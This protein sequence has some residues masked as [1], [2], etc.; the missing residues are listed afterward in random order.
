MLFLLLAGVVW[1]LARGTETLF[2]RDVFNAHLPMKQAQAEALR[3]GRMPLIDPYRAGGQPLAGN[4]NAVP[5]YPDNVLYLKA[6]VV[7]ALNAHFWI[8][9]LVAPFAFAWLARAWGIGR[10]GAWVAAALWTTGGFFL[11]HLSFYNLIAGV[12][13][14]PAFVAAVLDLVLRPERR[15]SLPLMAGLWGLLLLS[16]DPL[17]AGLALLVGVGAAV[18]ALAWRRGSGEG[19]DPAVAGRGTEVGSSDGGDRSVVWVGRKRGGDGGLRFPGGGMR[20]F[21]S[22]ALGM[23]GAL[24]AGTLLA[25][26][27]LVEFWRILALSFRGHWGFTAQAATIASWDP[28]QVVEQLIPFAFGRPD[29]LE[30]GSFW[31]SRF[32]TGFPPYYFSLYPGLLAFALA[33]AA[34]FRGGLRGTRASVWAWGAIAF[35]VFFSLGRFNPLASWL[36]SL[37]GG[38]ALRYPVKFWLPVAMG[39]ALLGGLG[40]EALRTDLRARRRFGFA[41]ALLAGLFGLAWTL[42]ALR[43]D[44]SGAWLRGWVPASFSEGFVVSERLRLAALCAVSLVLL[45]GLAVAFRVLRRWPVVGAALLVALH[46][47]S[48]LWLMRPLRPTDAVVPYRVPPPALDFVP[49]EAEVV[50]GAYLRLFGSSD[51]GSGRFPAPHSR[52]LER[53]AFFELYPM[54]GAQWR[55]RY[56]LNVSPEG[57]DSFLTRVSQGAVKGAPDAARV[58]LLAAW[59]VD[60]LL[61]DRPLDGMAGA[62]LA[63]IP[64]SGGLLHVYEVGGSAPDVYVARRI[65]RAPHLQAAVGWMLDPR[66]DP[67]ADVVLPGEGPIEEGGGGRVLRSVAADPEDLEVEVAVGGPSYL[68]VQ[69]AHLP[70]YRAS[71]DGETAAVEVGNLHRI[72]VAVPAG[73]HRVRLWVE[74][75]SLPWSFAASGVGAL[76]VALLAF[77]RRG[78]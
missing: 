68:V 46:A 2:L 36:L 33:A 17:M 24:A 69:R 66:F 53:R 9:L 37:V 11:S 5:F 26:P 35:G 64:S 72:A 45:G 23:V 16:G 1:P 18:C 51:L 56:E 22:P 77:R 39:L 38:G 42:L 52:W 55:R 65:W 4:P 75:G 14:A 32:Y 47:G 10:V 12:A 30:L 76:G 74:R 40:F 43:G 21:L 31:G 48:Q 70:L 59:G 13:L 73:R 15:R 61:L 41:L 19:S 29:L 7:W 49:A 25:A 20:R 78:R 6:P 27:Q 71:V 67:A 63:R 62:L 57:L 60:R 3:A 44:L 8:H 58:R 54:T 50:H 34:G 28:R